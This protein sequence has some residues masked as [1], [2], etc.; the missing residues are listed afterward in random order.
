MHVVHACMHTQ[1]VCYIILCIRIYVAVI[2]R[3]NFLH[4]I[5]EELSTDIK[6][7]TEK[8]KTKKLFPHCRYV[9]MYIQFTYMESTQVSIMFGMKG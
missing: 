3:N 7:N 2:W 1:Y 4:S 9:H 6:C 5:F 8:D